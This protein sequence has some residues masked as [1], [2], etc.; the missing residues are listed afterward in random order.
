VQIAPFYKAYNIPYVAKLEKMMSQV[1]WA[2][3]DLSDGFLKK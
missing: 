3:Q 1:V 2:R